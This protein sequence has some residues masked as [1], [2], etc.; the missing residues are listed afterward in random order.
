M[1]DHKAPQ[2]VISLFLSQDGRVVAHTADFHPDHPGGFTTQEA[3]RIRSRDALYR[4]VMRTMCNWDLAD[5][6]DQYA[7]EK[8]V[9]CLLEKGYRME[10]ISIGHDES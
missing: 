3:Q 9:K 1:S 6:C 2:G 10:Y 5:A 8:V 7:C 4:A